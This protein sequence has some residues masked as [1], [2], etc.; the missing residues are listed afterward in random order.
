MGKTKDNTAVSH[1]DLQKKREEGKL[2]DVARKESEARRKR[3][4]SET[5][6][7]ARNTAK[8]AYEKKNQ[9]SFLSEWGYYILIALGVA[10]FLGA[11]NYEPRKTAAQ[12]AEIPVIDDSLI[13]IHNEENSN[14]QLGTNK[15]F[16]GVNVLDARKLF[17]NY[18]NQKTV[19]PKCSA[20][21]NTDSLPASYN[22]KTEYPNCDK[23]PINQ[24]L[25]SSGWAI[26]V[27]SAFSDRFCQLSGDT[28]F[29]ASVQQLLTCEKRTSSACE[30]GYIVGALDYGRTK[31][32]VNKECMEYKPFDIQV[33]CNYTEINKCAQKEKILDYC[34]VEGG[35]NIKREIFVN[36]P[37]V[38]LFPAYRDWLVYKDGV[39]SPA[40]NVKRVDG[41]QALKVVGW[42]T[43]G[44]THYWIVENSFGEDWGISGMGK[45][46][47]NV[48][49]S[50]L[51]KTAV[52]VTPV[53]AEA[54]TD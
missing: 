8:K 43:E 9:K 28:A 34:N 11:W 42:N 24:G 18:F 31:G 47:M 20:S 49:D 4:Q 37:V 14:Y 1:E 32:F 26:A 52:S 30:R 33:D 10:V 50:S 5:K 38:S 36:G 15:I 19:I 7:K 29:R 3:E 54:E 53:V 22:W 2:T 48:S 21:K 6:T 39:Y 25:C 40:A 44:K 13:S 46:A 51:D 45:I 27:T 41:Y 16:D 23:S 17:N 12:I 35:E